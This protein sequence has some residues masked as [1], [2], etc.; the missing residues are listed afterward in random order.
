MN[1]KDPVSRDYLAQKVGLDDL[2]ADSKYSEN[3]RK[4]VK[5]IFRVLYDVLNY[6]DDEVI[7]FELFN[8][9]VR[10]ESAKEVFSSVGAK[11]IRY[12]LKKIN[13]STA[14]ITDNH[15]FAEYTKKYIYE[16]AYRLE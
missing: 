8:C 16:A 9:M 6:M 10:T 13:E 4:F 5:G 11:E 1:F 7:G 2:L 15:S 12:V 3:D 14:V